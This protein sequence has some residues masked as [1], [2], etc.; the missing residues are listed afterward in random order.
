MEIAKETF[1]YKE[2]SDCD[3]EL[4][5]Y[6]HGDGTDDGP[7]LLWIHGGALINGSRGTDQRQP[8]A[9]YLNAGYAVISI[10]YRLAPETK[11]PHIIEDLQDALHWTRKY[12][13]G[14]RIGVIGHSAGGYLTLMSGTFAEPPDALVSFYGY[15]DIVGDWYS[16]PDPFYCRQDLVTKEDAERFFRGAPV[17]AADQRAGNGPFYLYCRQQGIWP[18]EVGSRNPLQDPH[19]FVPYCPIQNIH[20]NY[21]PTLL[22]HGDEDT[23]VPYAQSVQ[24]AEALALQ[25]IENE[26]FSI[27]SGGHGFDSQEDDPQV[28]DAWLRIMSFLAKHLPTPPAATAKSLQ[29]PQSSHPPN[30][31]ND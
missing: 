15:G 18:Y 20:P 3:I 11:L 1:T 6:T 30:T 19:F 4:D 21:P 14:K 17:C 22:L 28:Q 23:D 26:L 8:F 10:D 24:M 5:V 2:T 27:K 16:K 31:H 9:H 25:G 13:P 12:R 29:S 7:V